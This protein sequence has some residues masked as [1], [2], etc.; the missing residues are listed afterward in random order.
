ML[1]KD[2][3][4]IYRTIRICTYIIQVQ[5]EI[6][7][8]NRPWFG[9]LQIPSHYYTPPV[10]KHEI[11]DTSWNEDNDSFSFWWNSV[12]NRFRTFNILE[13]M[14]YNFVQYQH[15]WYSN[16]SSYSIIVLYIFFIKFSIQWDFNKGYVNYIRILILAW[17]ICKKKL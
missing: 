3:I 11:F 4:G 1:R 9:P 14:K 5:N 16:C 7:K 12:I 2:K 13:F 15:S 6:Q 17:S 10:G 8:K